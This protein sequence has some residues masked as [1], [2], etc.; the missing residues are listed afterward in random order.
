MDDDERKRAARE[1]ARERKR[2]SRANA[3]PAK[4]EQERAANRERAH[5]R[6]SVPAYREAE[7]LATRERKRT[8]RSDPQYQEAERLADLERKRHRRESDPS[9]VARETAARREA[10]LD[11]EVVA[12][13][14]TARQEARLDS[15]VVARETTAR[16][17]ARLD[18]EV[19]ARETATRREAR[20]N[21]E[22]VAHETASRRKARLDPLVS[23]RE[24]E[25]KQEPRK[26]QHEARFHQAD[27]VA[28][29]L[30]PVSD[31]IKQRIVDD[32]KRQL[33]E[34]G[35]GE[36]TCLV[37][38][39]LV[40]TSL[41]SILPLSKLPIEK[42]KACLSTDQQSYHPDLWRQYDLSH[43]SP[44]FAGLP[45][46]PRGVIPH[47]HGISCVICMQCLRAINHVMIS[48]VGRLDQ[49]SLLDPIPSLSDCIKYFSPRSELAA[50]MAR[51]QELENLTLSR[52]FNISGPSADIGPAAMAPSI[53]M[54]QL[55]RLKQ[56]SSQTE[57]Q[58]E[59]QAV[60]TSPSEPTSA[61]ASSS[62]PIS[63]LVVPKPLQYPHQRLLTTEEEA[64]LQQYVPQ[65]PP[66]ADSELFVDNGLET[67]RASDMYRTKG[68]QW[69][70]NVIINR[71]IGVVTDYVNNEV[72]R[73]V[74]PSAATP[75]YAFSSLF[76]QRLSEAGYSGVQR[77]TRR[78]DIFSNCLIII[79]VN[80]NGVHWTLVTI[81]LDCSIPVRLRY[82]DSMLKHV[83]PYKVSDVLTVSGIVT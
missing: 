73:H 82:F 38:D 26:R 19:V 8:Q 36:H 37:C 44:S 53:H 29:T 5:K 63:R 46:S 18:P 68:G 20:L 74:F 1:A 70:S 71:F 52:H 76:Y 77:W 13:E 47:A 41:V 66:Q 28:L 10:R 42:M 39:R 32:A 81:D 50:E 21:P 78:V 69:F 40:L 75:C 14:T 35:M 54:S 6:R 59:P 34:F 30:S 64:K 2:K 27:G 51:L 79:P 57:V 25:A 23:A 80:I 43:V 31:D 65:D 83:T 67:V 4:L 11:P 24:N 33:G 7:Q 16:Q 61:A 62:A 9:V 3:D 58:P 49:L 56:S 72:H 55:P 12:R 17:E 15:E 48:R 45:L 22:V 60:F